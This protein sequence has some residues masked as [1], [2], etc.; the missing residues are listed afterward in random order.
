MGEMETIKDDAVAT[1]L[2][3]TGSMLFM[4]VAGLIGSIAGLAGA[5]IGMVIAGLLLVGLAFLLV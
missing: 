1:V 5:V 4:G 3:V 2:K